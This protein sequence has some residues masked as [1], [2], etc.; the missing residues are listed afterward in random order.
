MKSLSLRDRLAQFAAFNQWEQ[1]HRPVAR[2][3]ADVLADLG[4]IW[5][6]VP[7]DLRL[8]DPDP[9][10]AGLQQMR[11]VLARIAAHYAGHRP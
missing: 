3:F 8:A 1:D 5:T 4:F 9:E 6:W 2:P 11:A 7:R 10:K